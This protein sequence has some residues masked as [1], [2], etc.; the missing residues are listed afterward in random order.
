MKRI[1]QILSVYCSYA[2]GMNG[3]FIKTQTDFNH[4]AFLLSAKKDI[5][6]FYHF[7]KQSILKNTK[8]KDTIWKVIPKAIADCAL[9]LNE[10]ENKN[11]KDNVVMFEGT[12]VRNYTRSNWNAVIFYTYLYHNMW[13]KETSVKNISK[14]VQNKYKDYDLSASVSD[15][16]E[17]EN[18]LQIGKYYI[19][20]LKKTVNISK[21]DKTTIIPYVFVSEKFDS[22]TLCGKLILNNV[23][24]KIGN[25]YLITN[26]SIKIINGKIASIKTDTYKYRN[27]NN[28]NEYMIAE[29]ITS[30]QSKK[31]INLQ[32][33]NNKDYNCLY[34]TTKGFDELAKEDKDINRC[35]INASLYA[36]YSIPSIRNIVN[37]LANKPKIER[38]GYK[39][40]QIS[41]A[42]KQLFN[43]IKHGVSKFDNNQ[44]INDLINSL[45]ENY[46]V[47]LSAIPPYL[48]YGDI[49]ITRYD[50]PR[51]CAD[52]IRDRL[53]NFSKEEVINLITQVKI[54]ND[55]KKNNATMMK[56]KNL[57]KQS[58]TK[59]F[60][61]DGIINF[62]E[63]LNITKNE[64][65]KIIT[66]IQQE[67]EKA[68]HILISDTEDY[69]AYFAK[70]G[71]FLSATACITNILN[72]LYLENDHYSKI[73]RNLI[74][75]DIDDCKLPLSYIN[76]E[77]KDNCN[78]IESFRSTI[79]IDIKPTCKESILD[80]FGENRLYDKYENYIIVSVNDTTRSASYHNN[81]I[82]P[83]IITLK[84]TTGYKKYKIMST[85]DAQ[86]NNHFIA[87]VRTNQG[88][89]KVDPNKNEYLKFLGSTFDE[90]K[91][92]TGYKRHIMCYE[93]IS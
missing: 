87:T 89:Y 47:R 69:F 35:Y 60:T 84:T 2:N 90:N 46:Q 59:Y 32:V 62:I 17:Y 13:N 22:K 74:A 34:Q 54:Y 48:N 49:E 63:M 39:N 53:T 27:I 18:E 57:I 3:M 24:I 73:I 5:S 85:V 36:I 29:G 20:L 67:K 51:S 72:G 58:T 44:H 93:L 10:F 88:W 1:L 16:Q 33:L 7:E 81:V 19:P 79:I 76:D 38:Y 12:N 41:H 14:I 9:K 23:H 71:H 68:I 25:K 66:H 8:Y 64:S 70:T 52:C 6:T 26:I 77:D 56:I 21:R 30:K 83:E 75:T 43:D 65:S 82:C 91:S 50:I 4:F 86:H 28:L 15:V 42:L 61:Y 31:P 92:M 45:I 37:E 40:W 80:E 55:D 78:D 11:I